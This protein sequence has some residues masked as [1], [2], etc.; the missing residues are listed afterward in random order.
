[1][2]Y[3]EEERRSVSF[4]NPQLPGRTFVY[5]EEGTLSDGRG[6]Q[7]AKQG[8]KIRIRSADKYAH[9]AKQDYHLDG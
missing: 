5:C 1:M 4:V 6:K 3:K 7:P 9:V 2:Q 8:V